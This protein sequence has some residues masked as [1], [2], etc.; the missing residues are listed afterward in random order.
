MKQWV[1]R[2]VPLTIAASMMV[3]VLAACTKNGA[4]DSK[5]ERTL[6]VATYYGG[7]DDYF[8]TQFTDLFEFSN[9]NIKIEVV[10]TQDTGIRYTRPAPGEKQPDPMDRL[11]EILQGDNPPDIVMM[12]YEQLPE[13]VNSNLLTQLDPMI[14]KDKFNTSDIVPAVLEGLKKQGD[15][16]LYALTPSFF[17]SALIYNKRMFDEA[18][19]PYPKDGMTWEDTFDLARRVAK[20]DGDT[21]RYGFSFSSN[22]GGDMFYSMNMYTAPLQLSMFDAKG[23]KMTVDSDQWEKVWKTMAQLNSEKLI[24][25]QQD[26]NNMRQKM[27]APGGEDYNP[28]AYND[29]LSGRVA[30]T[31]V[32]YSELD[33]ITNANKNAQ[34][35]KGFT[36]IDWNVVTIPTHPEAPNVGGMI[37]MNGVMA[38]NAKA[39]NVEDAWKY[40]KF[41]NGDEWAKLKSRSNNQLIAR[42]PYLQKTKDGVEFNVEA[43]TKLTPAPANT[44]MSKIY[45]DKPNIYQVQEI[46]RNQ[47]SEFI[48]GKKTAREAL[49]EW[50]SKGDAALQQMK[51]N[52]NKPIDMGQPMPAI[53]R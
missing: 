1:K 36:P 26:R 43:F 35:V 46:G 10:S 21:R 33:Q 8:R 42:K 34:N 22:S 7:D 41:I 25:Q 9:P 13:L 4:A 17:S 16:K 2:A 50:Q 5:G 32:N 39:Q 19:V 6:R 29:F 18:G 47:F 20:G 30:M 51:D 52:P 38:I 24:P 45:R 23:E 31:I 3:P 12:N 53:Q 15:G 14:A 11:K 49:K 40:L 28:F 37:S 48:Q 44:E 27:M